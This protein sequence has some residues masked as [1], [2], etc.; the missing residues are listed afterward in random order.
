MKSNNSNFFYL[1]SEKISRFRDYEILYEGL[2]NFRELSKVSKAFQEVITS[3]N[4]TTYIKQ[5]TFFSKIINERPKI[6]NY[7]PF[8]PKSK[9]IKLMI[10]AGEY[11]NPLIKQFQKDLD[12]EQVE[13]L[14]EI[15]KNVN[16]LQKNIK[17]ITKKYE[18]HTDSLMIGCSLFY[19][20]LS[21]NFPY[22]DLR[23]SDQ[24]TKKMMIK[25]V[26]KKIDYLIRSEKIR[27]LEK[28]F[29]KFEREERIE[30]LYEH[31]KYIAKS[32]L[33]I[34]QNWDRENRPQVLDW[35]F[36]YMKNS[37]LLLQPIC[38]L[39]IEASLIFN[40]KIWFLQLCFANHSFFIHKK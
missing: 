13:I 20:Q 12:E 5:L 22:Y 2:F 24:E 6:Q 25:S 8:E 27:D 16:Q 14:K 3:G 39:F 28:T 31:N 30:I 10:S 38:D 32:E 17:I 1:F 34:F 9:K 7:S 33:F 18:S 11:Y 40:D 29:S 21:K 4:F 37:Q 19:K 35:Y 36:E 15:K 23:R 26:L